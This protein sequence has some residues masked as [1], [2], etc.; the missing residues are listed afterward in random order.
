MQLPSAL[1]CTLHVSTSASV[2]NSH[3]CTPPTHKTIFDATKFSYHPLATF[4]LLIHTFLVPISH[5]IA[6][7][8][9]ILDICL[10]SVLLAFEFAQGID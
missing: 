5:Y 1:L 9:H 3:V 7:S 10:K 2:Y 8:K 4:T 6:K